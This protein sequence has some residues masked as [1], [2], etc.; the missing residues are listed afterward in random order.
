METGVKIMF[1]NFD[2]RDSNYKLD[3]TDRL[4]FEEL[5]EEDNAEHF[6]YQHIGKCSELEKRVKELEQKLQWQPMEAAPKTGEWVYALMEIE[7]FPGKP[8]RFLGI[9]QYF[10]H[11]WISSTCGHPVAWLPSPPVKEEP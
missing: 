3:Y 7:P 1:S 11:K 4:Y 2:A 5:I 10:K 6:L 9:V 8:Q